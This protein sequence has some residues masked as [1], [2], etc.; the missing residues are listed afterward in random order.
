MIEQLQKLLN[1]V[2]SFTLA[3]E[4]LR[5]EKLARGDAFNLFSELRMTTDEVRLHSLF[6]SMLL[7]PFASHGQGDRFLKP[8]IEM[9]E[10]IVVLTDIIYRNSWSRDTKFC[11]WVNMIN[12]ERCCSIVQVRI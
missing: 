9:I 10:K 7:N 5:K 6:L 3:N 2:R 12:M 11:P 1:D 4:K 8:F